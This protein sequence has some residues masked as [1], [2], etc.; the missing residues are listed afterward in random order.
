MYYK[1]W[2]K[3]GH[4]FDPKKPPPCVFFIDSKAREICAA[5]LRKL[6]NCFRYDENITNI[7]LIWSY[8]VLCLHP[9]NLNLMLSMFTSRTIEFRKSK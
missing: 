8:M 1:K 7:G 5:L 2:I 6:M 4:F 3:M 9:L